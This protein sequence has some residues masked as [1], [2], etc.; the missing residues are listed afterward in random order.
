MALPAP[1]GS[2]AVDGAKAFSGQPTFVQ[3][4]ADAGPWPWLGAY[5]AIYLRQPA[6]RSVVDFLARNIAS[7]NPKVYERKGDTDRIEQDDHPL[8]ELLR[9]PNP[10]TTRY[11]LLRDTVSS[12]AIYDR[13]YWFKVRQG[14]DVVAVADIPPQKVTYELVP[15]GATPR[16]TYRIAEREVSRDDLGDF[17]GLHA[18]GGR[19]WRVAVRDA[20]PGPRRRFSRGS[21]PG[22][23]LAQRCPPAR[24]YRAP[25]RRSRMVR[26]RPS[27]VPGR[28]GSDLHGGA[29]LGAHRD[30]RRR[31]EME[32]V[33]FLAEGF[34]LRRGPR[35]D[36]PRGSHG[37]FRTGHRAPMVGSHRRRHHRE[38][39]PALPGRARAV[40]LV[41]PR[42]DRPSAT[43][44]S[45]RDPEP[46]VRRIQPGREAQRQL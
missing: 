40:A 12:Q 3:S 5:G 34:A 20:A 7:L 11:R 28:L 25:P 18:R 29:G 41:P 38:S 17:L 42:R 44:R 23:V 21:Q 13:A 22:R 39:P 15:N 9:H 26:H 24:R 27:P 33:Q 37:L 19:G 46:R 8:A 35:A 4:L 43:P 1:P 45:R 30:S 10:R 16:Y 36:L 2:F 14:P 6:V 31:H 32:S